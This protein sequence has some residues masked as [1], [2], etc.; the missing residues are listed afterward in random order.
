M[1]N[2]N[3]FAELLQSVGY[4]VSKSDSEGDMDVVRRSHRIL[5]WICGLLSPAE[6]ARDVQGDPDSS[7]TDSVRVCNFYCL[8]FLCR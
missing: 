8:L 4:P 6:V 5:P 3:S 1:E 2:E 7:L